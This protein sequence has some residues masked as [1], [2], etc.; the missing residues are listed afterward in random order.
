MTQPDGRGRGPSADGGRTEEHPAPGPTRPQPTQPQPTQPQPTQARPK[1][2]NRLGFLVSTATLVTA[3]AGSSSVIPLYNTY[4]AENGLTNADVALTVVVYFV[5][6]MT[7]LLVLGRIS[8]YVG[9]RRAAMLTL[10]L[11]AAGCVVLLNVTSV[12]QVAI[13][14]GLMGLGCGVATSAVMAYIVDT[15]PTRPVWLAAVVTSQSPLLGLT[16]GGLAAGAL[17]EYGPYPRDTIYV[18]VLVL[19]VGCFVGLLFC[20][21]TIER[22]PGVLRSL[23]PQVQIPKQPARIL[24]VALAIFIATWA[25]GGY[26]QSFSPTI[27]R[28]QL[29]TSNAV[30]M[31]LVYA[32]YMAPSVIGGPAGGRY[33]PASAQRIGM[34]IFLAG[35]ALLVGGLVTQSVLV[36][37]LGGCTA[38]FAQ[39]MAGSATIRV[40]LTDLESADRAP[41]LAATYLASYGGAMVPSLIAGQLTK[42]YGI[43]QI[44][45]GYLVLAL[46]ATGLTFAAARNVARS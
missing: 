40:L 25:M 29:G 18:C 12:L 1:Q 15:A 26:F 32:S 2:Q 45:S 33:S 8:N 20:P 5:G 24:W 10:A 21:E 4:R 17:I 11:V 9:R 39:G 42:V 3:F 16:I 23:R 37:L 27:S 6:T 7:A 34:G 35:M 43:V 22:R 13:G 41:V 36:V 46:L 28:D 44:S 14:R 38:G 30:V 19:I 31:A